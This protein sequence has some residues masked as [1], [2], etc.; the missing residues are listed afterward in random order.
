MKNLPKYTFEILL[1]LL[2]LSAYTAHSLYIGSH[3]MNYAT[4]YISGLHLN[5]GGMPLYDSLLRGGNFK[6]AIT[7]FHAQVYPPVYLLGG[8][9]ATMVFG[10]NWMIMNL[11]QNSFYLIMALVFSY[12]LASRIAGRLAGIMNALILAMLPAVY[13]VFTGFIIDSALMGLAVMSVYFLLRSESFTEFRWS[14]LFGIACGWGMMVKPSFGA[15]ILGIIAY[16]LWQIGAQ[17]YKKKRGPLRNFTVSVLV[18]A[19]LASPY[20]F[21]AQTIMRWYKNPLEEVSPIPWHSWEI[22][23][24][25]TVGI[26]ENQLTPPFFMAF[27]IGLFY[28]FGKKYSS[29]IKWITSLWVLVPTLMVLFMPHWKTT[30][31]LL[32]VLPAYSL[33]AAVGLASI[34]V[35]WYGRIVVLLIL[36]AGI[37]QYFGITYGLG[38]PLAVENENKMQATL[39]PLR[40]YGYSEA[41]TPFQKRLKRNNN[42]ENAYGSI[43]RRIGPEYKG[44]TARIAMIDSFDLNDINYF[45][46]H[47]VSIEKRQFLSYLYHEYDEKNVDHIM[48][49]ILNKDDAGGLGYSL[50][51]RR[52][53]EYYMGQGSWAR[54]NVDDKGWA[55]LEKIWGK[56]M[57]SYSVREK[58]SSN[59]HFSV[60][61][62]SKK[63]YKGRK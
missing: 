22:L 40:Y 9:I 58:L 61:L 19:L 49:G 63:P 56:I 25:F 36:A 8:L 47:D 18:T 16:P 52:I 62:Y 5:L 24:F 37:L 33:I 35:K 15:V 55:R 45:W 21:S 12:L 2:I 57:V 39:M 14:V 43:A 32:P 60:Y 1:L 30:Y 10:K 11:A 51:F 7:Q 27:L 48:F 13:G 29:E 17:A 6:G 20:Y 31:Y 53:K 23:R 4:D 54:D 38:L 34:S 28:Y 41:A 26:C 3:L 46:F 44:K 50:P 59:D 42:Y